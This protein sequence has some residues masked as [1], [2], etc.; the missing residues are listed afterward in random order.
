MTAKYYPYSLGILILDLGDIDTELEPWPS[1]RNPQDLVAKNF[2]SEL[3]PI[4]SRG[5][6]NSRIRM[7]VANVVCLHKGVHRCVYARRRPV[8]FMPTVVKGQNHIVFLVN[9]AVNGLEASDAVQLQDRKPTHDQRAKVAAR[10]LN[11]Q[12]LNRLTSCRVCGPAFGT[13]VASR[14]ISVPWVGA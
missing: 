11:P 6:N 9:T 8:R 4:S 10:T 7:K 5:N 12:Q 14:K 3:F 1:P 2:P 13:G